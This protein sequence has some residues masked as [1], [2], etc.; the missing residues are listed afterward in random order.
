MNGV[1]ASPAGQA[2]AVK[3]VAN[4]ASP[5]A[6]WALRVMWIA[7]GVLAPWAAAAEGR[8]DA[9]RVSVLAWGWGL[10]VAVLVALLVPAAA[11]LTAVRAVMPVAFV[12]AVADG[13][14]L[15]VAVV[16][17][18]WAVA[19]LPDT[20]DALVQGGAYG[21]E[22]R[23]LLRTPVTYA[24]PALLAISAQW[25]ALLGGSLL[26]AAHRWVPGAVLTVV[27]VALLR[28]VPRQLHRLSRRWLVLVPAGIVVH[29]HVVLAETLMVRTAQVSAMELVTANGEAADLTGG[30]FGPR[31]SVTAS[32]AD[33]VIL[34]PITAK[35]LGT[36]EAL[37]VQ[38]FTVAPR[39]TARALSMLLSRRG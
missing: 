6:L 37:H 20:A 17:A 15:P 32:Q 7:V 27:G 23:F 3:P 16:I 19:S 39:R 24:L 10:W 18:A 14:M 22:T 12:A 35:T 9:V 11:S 5:L 25:T 29:D 21:D 1:P 38:M 33:K 2:C 13:R 31:I 28:S 30:V 8:S 26:L 4:G 34:S 36:A